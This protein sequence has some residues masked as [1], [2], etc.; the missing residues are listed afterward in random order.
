ML[1]VI[2]GQRSEDRGQLSE[3]NIEHRTPNIERRIPEDRE[4]EIT[5]HP[6]RLRTGA[7]GE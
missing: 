5:K 1:A 4:L 7:A 6:R 3:A 2:R